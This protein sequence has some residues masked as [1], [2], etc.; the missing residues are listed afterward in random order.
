MI[1]PALIA[2]SVLA[3]APDTALA[4][5]EAMARAKKYDKDPQAQMYRLNRLYPPLTK[6]MPPIFEACAPGATTTG[7]PNFTV[8]LSFKA[9]AFDAIR[10]TS[11][12][13]IAQCV[14]GKMANL[15]YAPPP[16]PDFAEEIHLKMGEE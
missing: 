11:D 3:A 10:H 2:V 6:A 9:G 1:L 7:R 12:H 8:V 5:A 13:P 16:F 4:F 15:K 14:A